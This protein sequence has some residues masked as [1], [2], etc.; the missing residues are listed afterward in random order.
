MAF[1]RNIQPLCQSDYSI[2]E[3]F[4]DGSDSFL[5]ESRDTLQ[6]PDPCAMRDIKDIVY[7]WT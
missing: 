5:V 7:Y 3:C 4:G 2:F 6:S 1:P